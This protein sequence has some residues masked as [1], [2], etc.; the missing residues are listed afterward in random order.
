MLGGAAARN[1]LSV[2]VDVNDDLSPAQ[3]LS[4]RS[5]QPNSTQ[6]A[7]SGQQL[8]CHRNS[9]GG[10]KGLRQLSAFLMRLVDTR[11]SCTVM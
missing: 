10:K 2:L 4:C 7:V 3:F 5:V 11:Q 1:V 6:V 9:R 8:M